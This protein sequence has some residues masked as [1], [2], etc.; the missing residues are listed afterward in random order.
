[1]SSQVTGVKGLL[2]RCSD[3]SSSGVAV[4]MALS[5][6]FFALGISG[7]ATA[8][9]GLGVAFLAIGIGLM[10]RKRPHASSQ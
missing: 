5:A 1:M 4:W 10:K 7:P 2:R 8:Y 6:A 3:A 9:F